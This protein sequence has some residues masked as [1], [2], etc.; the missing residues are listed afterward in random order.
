[1]MAEFERKVKFVIPTP[2]FA[3]VNSSGNPAD[4]EKTGSL[5]PQE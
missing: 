3:R 5:L 2:A 4:L 1:M